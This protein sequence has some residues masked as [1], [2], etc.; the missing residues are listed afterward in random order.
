MTKKVAK[1]KEQFIVMKFLMGLNESFSNT[2]SQ[3]LLMNPMPTLNQIFYLVVYEERQRL[4]IASIISA[5]ESKAMQV[6]GNFR[7]NQG[8]VNGQ[9]QNG[10]QNRNDTKM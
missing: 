5:S 6:H 4:S 3:I 7:P 2:M 10:N 1:R 8:N 9:R